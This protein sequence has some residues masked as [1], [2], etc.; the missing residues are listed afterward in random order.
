MAKSNFKAYCEHV[1]AQLKNC[2]PEDWAFCFVHYR[3]EAF[4]RY[5]HGLI[6]STSIGIN[7]FE[8]M[9]ACLDGA[10]WDEKGEFGNNLRKVIELNK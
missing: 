4:R 3:M 2:P 10:E 1:L 5:H 7:Y 6:L 9:L 8:I